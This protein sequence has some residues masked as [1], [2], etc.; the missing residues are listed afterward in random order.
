VHE[1]IAAVDLAGGLVRQDPRLGP[2]VLWGARALA[3]LDLMWARHVLD[4][5]RL[6]RS[7]LRSPVTELAV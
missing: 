4:S 5:W 1:N 7:S 6:E 3:A 2:D